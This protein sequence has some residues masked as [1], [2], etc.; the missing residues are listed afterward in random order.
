MLNGI[1]KLLDGNLLKELCDMGHGDEIAIVDANYPAYTFGN[2]V[3]SYPGVSATEL[4]DAIIKIFPIDH[5]SRNQAM[6][7]E[8]E[9]EDR[10]A[11]KND[12]VIWQ[13]FRDIIRKQYGSNIRYGLLSRQDFY[14]ESKKAFAI[15][16]TGEERIYGNIILVKGVVK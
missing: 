11:E 15:I 1:N 7:M 9:P 10:K 14:D 13:D 4:L 2:R 5:I 3:L 6:L 16:Q 8:V 12:P